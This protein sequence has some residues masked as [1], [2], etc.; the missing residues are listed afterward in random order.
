MKTKQLQK[1]NNNHN[2]VNYLS[3]YLS[4]YLSIYGSTAL[5]D[6]GRFFGFLILYTV[7]RTSWTGFQ[8]VAR[9]LPTHRTSQTQNK[10]RQTSMPRLRFEP[11]IPVFEREKTDCAATVFASYKY[12]EGLWPLNWENLGEYACGYK[13]LFREKYCMWKYNALLS[14]LTTKSIIIGG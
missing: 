5:V 12:T 4:I 2:I 7:G 13:A 8:P 10:H 9:P 1:M 11:T 6:L 3:T 14:G